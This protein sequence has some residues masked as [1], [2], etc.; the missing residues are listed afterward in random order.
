ML[1]R[2]P[3]SP[4]YEQW[5]RRHGAPRGTAVGRALRYVMPRFVPVQPWAVARFGMFSFQKNNDTRRWEYPWIHE[6]IGDPAG[7]RILDIGGS[8][9]GMQFVLAAEGGDVTNLDP[10]LGAAGLGWKVDRRSLDN[11]TEATGTTVELIPKTFADAQLPP[12]SFDVALSI[13]TIEHIP[14]VELR[15]LFEQI[16]EVLAPGGIFVMTVD[17]FLDLEPF[18]TATSNHWGTNVDMWDLVQ[19]SGLELAVGIPEEL[20]GHPDFDVV[21]VADHLDDYIVGNDYPTLVQ[22]IVLR[23]PSDS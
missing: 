17:L 12:S 23:R 1:A 19:R 4:A 21:Q 20:Y 15:S 3:L 8:L 7:K 22:A 6:M 5:N 11:M 13:S 16:G 14:E 18:T 10:G 2:Q 9:A